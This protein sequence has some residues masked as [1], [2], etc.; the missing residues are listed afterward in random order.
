LTRLG[1]GTVGCGGA[2]EDMAAAIEQLPE[3]YVAAAY[4][5]LPERAR[6]LAQ[7]HGAKAHRS[8][9][10]LFADRTVDVV[11][12]ALPHHLLAPTAMAALAA[13]KHVLVEKPMALD[14]ETARELERLAAERGRL[15][16]PVLELRTSAVARE[17]RR[18]VTGGAIGEVTSVRIRTVIDKPATYWQ[19]G[20]RGLVNDSWRARRA[21]AG[22]GV[23]LMNS[24]HQLD[25]VRY[26]T[27]H[28]FVRA[29]AEIATLHADVEVEDS[30]AA[31][32]RLSNGGIAS[33]AAAAHSPGATDEERLEIDGTEGRI[34]LPDPS[35][36]P[37]ALRVFLRRRWEEL[38]AGRKLDLDIGETDTYLELL[39]GFVLALT[40]NKPPPVTARDAAKALA[41]VLAIYES[42]TTGRAVDIDHAAERQ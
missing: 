23:V 2:A 17:A 42:S 25:L 6:A 36:N 19:S 13:G 32:L 1:I 3:T 26:V 28:S 38:P 18:L 8:V 40:E 15:I 37:G 10:E 4:D 11:Y 35:R 21:E 22:G 31:V 27:G 30:A 41:T 24:I 5:T 39:R 7:A 34:D 9:E 12:I 20:P 33:L 16:V 14:V 29:S